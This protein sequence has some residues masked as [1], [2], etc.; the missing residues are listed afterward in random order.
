MSPAEAASW[1]GNFGELSFNDINVGS[2]FYDAVAYIYNHQIMTGMTE[3]VFGPYESTSRAQFAVMLYRMEGE[4]EVNDTESAFADVPAGQ[5]FSDA[6]MWGAAG[7]DYYRIH[8]RPESRIVRYA[9]IRLPENRWPP[10][11]TAMQKRK[12]MT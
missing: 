9:Q 4:P 1:P 8:R 6:I 2:W 10:C 5:W 7:R 11:F 3:N 12:A